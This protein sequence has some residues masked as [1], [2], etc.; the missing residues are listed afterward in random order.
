MTDQQC[1]CPVPFTEDDLICADCERRDQEVHERLHAGLLPTGEA[2]D[3][4]V[5]QQ[6]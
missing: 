6:G 5:R 3:A 4:Y 1:A 2:Y